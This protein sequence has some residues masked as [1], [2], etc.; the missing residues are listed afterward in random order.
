MAVVA[1]V[2]PLHQHLGQAAGMMR[3]GA[4]CYHTPLDETLHL[5]LANQT[6]AGGGR[7]VWPDYPILKTRNFYE[8]LAKQ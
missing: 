3:L 1:P 2:V 7:S 4:H 8:Q 5:R 6:P